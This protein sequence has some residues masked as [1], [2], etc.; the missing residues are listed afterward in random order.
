MR[1]PHRVN[2]A[3]CDK[4]FREKRILAELRRQRGKKTNIM[5]ISALSFSQLGSKAACRSLY[6]SSS[7]TTVY[8]KTREHDLQS[9]GTKLSLCMR[10]DTNKLYTLE[11]L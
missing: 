7:R 11:R 1:L 10:K 2:I 5:C 3:A 9:D 6:N 4:G 8:L